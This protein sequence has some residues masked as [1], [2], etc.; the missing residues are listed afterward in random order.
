MEFT[1][2]TFFKNGSVKM[3]KVCPAVVAGMVHVKVSVL[4]YLADLKRF[5]VDTF[6]LYAVTPAVTFHTL[7]RVF[8]VK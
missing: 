2:L 5:E 3:I 8:R 7:C 4:L 1:S 6:A